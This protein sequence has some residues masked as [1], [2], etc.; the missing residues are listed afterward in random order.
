MTHTFAKENSAIPLRHI[1]LPGTHDSATSTL[2]TKTLRTDLSPSKAL[3]SLPTT[4]QTRGLLVNMA[5]TQTPPFGLA[6][7]LA[8]GVRFFDLRVIF[9]GGF[10]YFIHGDVVWD[11]SV[12][13][14]MEQVGKFLDTRP[15][16]FVM[17]RFSHIVF[18]GPQ[19]THTNV[20]AG[21]ARMVVSALGVHRVATRSDSP[22][23]QT[24]AFQVMERG[25][26]VMVLIDKDYG[27]W[28]NAMP[29]QITVSREVLIMN[30]DPNVGTS[31]T[32]LLKSAERVMH[33][34]MSPR[35]QASFRNVQLH[36]QYTTKS[37][38]DQVFLQGKLR[39]VS[40]NNLGVVWQVVE[41]SSKSNLALNIAT[42][43]FYSA[44]LTDWF[45]RANKNRLWLLR[46]M[47]LLSWT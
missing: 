8:M 16:E 45:V 23:A 1:I 4:S 43:D 13:S 41:R 36:F 40:P 15:G 20:L 24:Y 39:V 47:R 33:E 17:L 27:D 29:P 46:D 11:T 42:F 34:N 5:R 31:E 35:A 37:I 30:Y 26:N 3:H 9:R 28:V 10:P 32:G 12:M 2:T 25:R 38:T 44:D 6:S 19:A 7:Q 21:F 22:V 14:E 18:T